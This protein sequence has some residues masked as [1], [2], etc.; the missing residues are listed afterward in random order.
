MEDTKAERGAGV[1]GVGV[2][3]LIRV[4]RKGLTFEQRCE[5]RG[6]VYLVAI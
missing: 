1:A 6:S 2:T 4:F 5:K 3:I